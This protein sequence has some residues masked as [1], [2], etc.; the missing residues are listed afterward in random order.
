MKASS[1]N[2]EIDEKRKKKTKKKH[3]DAINANYFRVVE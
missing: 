2:K 3:P 1:E